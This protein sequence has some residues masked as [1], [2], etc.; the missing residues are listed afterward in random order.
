MSSTRTVF[1]TIVN[2]VYTKL[3]DLS[4]LATRHVTKHTQSPFTERSLF[5]TTQHMDNNKKHQS[6]KNQNKTKK[7]RAQQRQKYTKKKK[8]ERKQTKCKNI[9]KDFKEIYC[10]LTFYNG[11]NLFGLNKC[12][13]FWFILPIYNI[14]LC[15]VMLTTLFS[16]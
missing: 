16:Q 11:E 4:F 2:M 8:Q 1:T 3:Y 7:K 15:T 6:N 9:E 12:S 5:K 10:N 14:T 13:V